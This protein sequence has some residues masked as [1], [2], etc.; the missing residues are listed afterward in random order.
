MKLRSGLDGNRK[1]AI[2]VVLGRPEV[3]TRIGLFREIIGDGASPGD[4]F[5]VVVVVGTGE[6]DRLW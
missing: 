2:L 4:R 3:I 1:C 5:A 6:G